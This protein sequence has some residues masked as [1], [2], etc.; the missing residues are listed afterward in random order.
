MME[1][2]DGVVTK[3]G[4]F[5]E[6]PG[7]E[8]GRYEILKQEKLGSGDWMLIVKQQGKHH[9]YSVGQTKYYPT[10]YTLVRVA[11]IERDPKVDAGTLIRELPRTP[12]ESTVFE[13]RFRVDDVIKEIEPGH[14]WREELKNLKT[15][16][17]ALIWEMERPKS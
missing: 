6:M 16:M 7:F 12:R 4:K 13:G 9:W 15:E 14:K 5:F 8:D 1:G 11:P 17:E 3:S 10:T 2:F